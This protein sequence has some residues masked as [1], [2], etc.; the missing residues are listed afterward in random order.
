MM[1]VGQAPIEHIHA[2]VLRAIG[3]LKVSADETPLIRLTTNQKHRL[4]TLA[5]D[6]RRCLVRLSRTFDG[7]FVK[8]R[9]TAEQ[10]LF[11]SFSG[12]VCAVVRA[13][14][15]CER[16]VGWTEIEEAAKRLD[17]WKPLSEP[18][19]VRW[20]PKSYKAGYRLICKDGP[21]RTAQRLLVR[22]ALTVMGV[23]SEFD[24]TRKGAEGERGLVQKVCSLMADEHAYW[25]TPDV[26]HFFMSLK[27]KHFGW[28]PLDRRLIKDVLFLPKC[29]KI[30]VITPKDPKAVLSWMKASFP[31]LPP[32]GISSSKDELVSLTAHLVRQGLPLGSV[33]SPLLARGFLGRELR[34]ALGELGVAA[35][36]FCDDLA[37]G[38]C[39]KSDGQAAVEAL[40]ERLQSHPAGPIELHD[41]ELLPRTSMKV[42]LLGY[43]L[44]PGNGYGTNPVHVK[45]GPKRTARLRAKM[46]ER[47]KRAAK[48]GDDLMEVGLAYNA[49]WYASQQAW[50]KVPGDSWNASEC[51]AMGYVE[52][53][54]MGI[55]LGGNHPS[56][57]LLKQS[58]PA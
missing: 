9:R 38:A 12:R 47:L 34:A 42:Q 55:P 28:L 31:D 57:K 29:A 18:V 49:R 10:L 23:D 21:E 52:D 41:A 36:S 22:D 46:T 5:G 51:A 7:D 44:E 8:L 14:V 37:I 45:P 50:T 4:E 19:T 27:P 26:K 33:T 32:V 53:F 17:V 6:Y 2:D 39:F 43:F 24:F 16:K 13:F 48:A 3:R 58:C 11:A 54:E 25:W 15:R 30:V 35:F 1:L 20:Q 56:N 40:T